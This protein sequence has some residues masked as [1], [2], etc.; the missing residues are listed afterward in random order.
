MVVKFL[1]A[2]EKTIQILFGTAFLPTKTQFKKQVYPWDYW[3]SLI[4]S[5]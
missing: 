2:M 3:F 4:A 1:V 5:L